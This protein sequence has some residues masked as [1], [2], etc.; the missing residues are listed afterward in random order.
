M[1]YHIWWIMALWDLYGI[2]NGQFIPCLIEGYEFCA[3]SDKRGE[4]SG[5]QQLPCILSYSLSDYLINKNMFL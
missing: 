4:L 3:N 2:Y 5:I 1:Q